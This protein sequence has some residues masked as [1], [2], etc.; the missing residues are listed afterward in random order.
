MV[1]AKASGLEPACFA[2]VLF[3]PFCLERRTIDDFAAVHG[4]KVS[5]DTNVN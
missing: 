4:C 2:H 3:A 5:E 1:S